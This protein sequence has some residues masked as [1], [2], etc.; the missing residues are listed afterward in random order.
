[1]LKPSGG[2]PEVSDEV[3][4][5]VVLYART[6]GVPARRDPDD[7]VV[8]AG[9]RLFTQA[10][11]PG[12]HVAALQTGPARDLPELAGQVIH[13]YTD[14]LLH[15]MG[16]ALGDGRPTFAASGGEWRTAPLWGVGLIPRVNGHGFLLHDGRARNVS[17]AI[18]WH[19]GE[20]R[21]ARDRFVRLSGEQRAALIRFVESL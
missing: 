8:R 13:P 3:L 7:P 21:A 19:D 11:C 12:C 2:T 18:L 9:E 6:L 17:E 10:G 20:A 4:D 14:L 16:G 5:A 15:D 1:V